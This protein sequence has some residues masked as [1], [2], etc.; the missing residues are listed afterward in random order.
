MYVISLKSYQLN[1]G[2]N[3]YDCEDLKN[4][5]WESLS[6]RDGERLFH[7]KGAATGKARC[8]SLCGGVA[9]AAKMESFYSGISLQV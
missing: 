3:Y 5:A 9:A 8:P 1:T 7:T 6:W 4:C 2:L